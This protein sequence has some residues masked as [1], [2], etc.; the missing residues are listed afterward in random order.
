MLREPH[1]KIGKWQL[2]DDTTVSSGHETRRLTPRAYDLLVYLAERPGQLVTSD[3][4]VGALWSHQS[5]SDASVYKLM[6]E[7]RRALGDDPRAP[8]YIKTVSRRGYMLVAETRN[9]AT[10]AQGGD[11]DDDRVA[12]TPNVEQSVPRADHRPLRRPEGNIGFRPLSYNDDDLAFLAEALIGSL[13]LRSARTH[14]EVTVLPDTD[15]AS[16][17]DLGRSLGLDYIISGTL[18]ASGDRVR[19]NCRIT[20]TQRGEEVK[21]FR[22]DEQND[23]PLA[24]EDKLSVIAGAILGALERYELQVIRKLS[25]DQ[26]DARGLN[27]LAQTILVTDKESRDRKLDLMRRAIELDPQEGGLRANYAHTLMEL[28]RDSFLPITDELKSEML[29]AVDRALQTVDSEWA[30]FWCSE[31][32]R[33]FGDIHLSRTLAERASRGTSDFHRFNAMIYDGR[34]EEV[35]E[36]LRKDPYPDRG[37]LAH[38]YIIAG[39]LPEAEIAIRECVGAN[40]NDRWAWASLANNLALQ[41]RLEEARDAL[42]KVRQLAPRWTFAGKEKGTRIHWRDNAAVVDPQL[43]GLRRLEAE[44]H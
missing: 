21:A 44:G 32:H 35:I 22:L 24:L 39:R 25:V 34:V 7:L 38:A 42:A 5:V 31:I 2:H 15:A 6:S 11:T 18:R 26:L 13:T 14:Y 37:R 40:P 36:L 23:D 28:M 1:L 3:E 33:A 27:R 30:L 10:P 29:G 16:A 43:D 41:G 17:I 8:T 9:A 19:L 12:A 4:V 20:E